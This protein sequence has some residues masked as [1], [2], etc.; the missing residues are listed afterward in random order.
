MYRKIRL[1]M[2]STLKLI[3]QWRAIQKNMPYIYTGSQTKGVDA[4][5]LQDSVPTYATCQ[6][7]CISLFWMPQTTQS[8]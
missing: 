5:V 8:T 2:T 4:V 7:I 1:F 6:T 3:T